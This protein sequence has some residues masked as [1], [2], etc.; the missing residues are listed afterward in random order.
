MSEK[1]LIIA[2]LGVLVLGT[3]AFARVSSSSSVKGGSDSAAESEVK[4]R[5]VARAGDKR[6]ADKAWLT[7]EQVEDV[8]KTKVGDVQACWMKLAKGKRKTDVNIT[9]K[10]EI[11]D[12]GEVQTV[13]V[14]GT[15]PHET[16]RCIE[17]AAAA[18]EF[19]ATEVK[20]DTAYFECALVL[21]AK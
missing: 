8:V 3:S 14:N 11:D 21:H 5:R 2:L 6:A 17:L 20:I 13:V 19:P 7:E 1:K 12:T 16:E 4:V 9:L 15:V 18:W 10:L